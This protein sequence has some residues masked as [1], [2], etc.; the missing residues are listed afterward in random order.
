MS[1]ADTSKKLS[2]AAT[3]VGDSDGSPPPTDLVLP[4]AHTQFL[5]G[6][7]ASLAGWFLPT[8]MDE[9]EANVFAERIFP[10][11]LPLDSIVTLQSIRM[12]FAV[13]IFAVSIYG[14]CI[15]EI[16]W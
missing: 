16:V 11:L 4:P 9:I 13:F 12:A 2:S 7:M 1:S 5:I 3:Q 14:S 8:S 6:I 10:E 15:E